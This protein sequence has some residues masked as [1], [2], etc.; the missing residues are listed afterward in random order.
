MDPTS[1]F[2]QK[3]VEYLE[4]VHIREFMT[5]TQEEV[6][7]HIEIEKT[8]NPNYQDPTP[9]LYLIHHHLYVKIQPVMNRIVIIV[10][11]LKLGGKNS[12]K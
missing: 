10:K 9:R 8:Q 11:N 12:E 1:D 7:H 2:K 3:I 6:K 4:S 5:G